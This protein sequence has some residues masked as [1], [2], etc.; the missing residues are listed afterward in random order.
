MSWL[1]FAKKINEKYYRIFLYETSD[2][3][4]IFESLGSFKG[5][6]FLAYTDTSCLRRLKIEIST[7]ELFISDLIEN[8]L[9]PLTHSGEEGYLELVSL[10]L[11]PK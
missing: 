9:A 8:S 11:Y 1:T 5:V 7:L 3:K 10:D 4:E 2:I 6:I